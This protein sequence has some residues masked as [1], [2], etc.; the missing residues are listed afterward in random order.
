MDITLLEPEYRVSFG[1]IEDIPELSNKTVTVHASNKSTALREAL[2]QLECS[3]PSSLVRYLARVEK[4][5]EK[6]E[7][8]RTLDR[9]EKMV[10]DTL[11]IANRDL[12]EGEI[13]VIVISKLVDILKD[14]S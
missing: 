7:V 4:L 2:K 1:T 11:R 10:R 8:G 14:I 6:T 5:G 3:F 9:V 12:P 13:K